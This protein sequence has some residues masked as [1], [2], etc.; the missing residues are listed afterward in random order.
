MLPITRFGEFF[1][2]MWLCY[3]SN[4]HM[5]NKIRLTPHICTGIDGEVCTGEVRLAFHHVYARFDERAEPY[6]ERL[7]LQRVR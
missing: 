4:T 7:A 2:S 3:S 6:Q 5:P 1:R